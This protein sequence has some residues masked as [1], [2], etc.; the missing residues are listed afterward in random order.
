MLPVTIDQ[1]TVDVKVIKQMLMM[2]ATI[3]CDAGSCCS[4]VCS[5][6]R[7]TTCSML[8]YVY[9]TIQ[10]VNSRLIVYRWFVDQT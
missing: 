7:E 3:M 1:A 9:K 4:H 10:K 2:T 6:T 5:T 8:N